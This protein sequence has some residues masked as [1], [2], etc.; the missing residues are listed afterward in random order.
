MCGSAD[1]IFHL[2][3]A[4]P[5]A[6]VNAAQIAQW[7]EYLRL[8][9]ALVKAILQLTPVPKSIDDRDPIADGLRSNSHI[10]RPPKTFSSNLISTV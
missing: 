7:V 4:A 9:K 10:E 3:E 6:H 2:C 1:N 5:R 8:A